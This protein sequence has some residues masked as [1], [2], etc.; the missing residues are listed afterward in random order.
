VDHGLPP[1]KDYRLDRTK[2]RPI[3]LHPLAVAIVVPAGVRPALVANLKPIAIP[4][5]SPMHFFLHFGIEKALATLQCKTQKD[6]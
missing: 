2:A 3:T 4:K 1:L 6:A 5:C